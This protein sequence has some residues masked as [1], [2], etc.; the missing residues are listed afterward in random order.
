MIQPVL[1]YQKKRSPLPALGARSLCRRVSFR[2]SSMAP[3]CPCTTGLGRPV[4]P[5]V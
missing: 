5:L 2:P 1:V 3:P 4:V